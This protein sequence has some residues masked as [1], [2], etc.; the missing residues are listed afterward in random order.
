MKL[1]NG[2]YTSKDDIVEFLE[3]QQNE[4]LKIVIPGDLLFDVDEV[5][6]CPSKEINI[7]FIMGTLSILSAV[8][9][10]ILIIY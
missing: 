4:E 1:R 2:K 7:K 3:N 10:F 6:F 8:I 5:L 9:L